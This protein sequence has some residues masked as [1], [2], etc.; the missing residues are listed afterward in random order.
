LFALE[1]LEKMSDSSA[2]AV[3]VECGEFHAEA[4][5][6]RLTIRI[7]VPAMASIIAAPAAAAA[8]E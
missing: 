8:L 2:N 4:A 3:D 7:V 6:L 5:T 1:P